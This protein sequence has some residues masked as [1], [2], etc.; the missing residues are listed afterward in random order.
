M[1]M[2]PFVY[3]IGTQYL[4]HTKPCNY[5]AHCALIINTCF[6]KVKI[7]AQSAHMCPMVASCDMEVASCDVDW[8]YVF[9]CVHTVSP[10]SRG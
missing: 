6:W 2:K 5:N 3:D 4:M 10:S 7:E 1:T 9:V 8:S